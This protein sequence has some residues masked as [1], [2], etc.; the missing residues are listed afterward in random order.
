MRTQT[1]PAP[2]RRWKGKPQ[3]NLVV[4]AHP[5][6]YSVAA[7]AAAIQVRR[8]D[9]FKRI[10][11]QGF[12]FGLYIYLVEPR[13]VQ[14]EDLRLIHFGELLVTK[15][16]THL[17]GHLEAFEGVNPPLRRAPPQ[18]ISPPDRVIRAIVLDVLAPAIRRHHRI[19]R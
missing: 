10:R 14:P 11:R 19:V 9:S 3:V 13:G 12:A 17:V 2:T 6:I 16:F 4:G 5:T 1:K 7:Q 15:L 8:L 18:A